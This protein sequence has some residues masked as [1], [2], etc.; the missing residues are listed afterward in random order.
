ME[1]RA[2][3]RP[4][5]ADRGKPEVST[6]TDTETSV[7]EREGIHSVSDRPM[8]TT[9]SRIIAIATFVAGAHMLIVLLLK[10]GTI[11]Q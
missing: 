10:R 11:H 6:V 1:G 2:W 3:L 7:V 9:L 8:T 5:N 4:P